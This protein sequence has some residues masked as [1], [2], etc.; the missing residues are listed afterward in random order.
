MKKFPLFVPILSVLLLHASLKQYAIL[1][2]GESAPAIGVAIRLHRLLCLSIIYSNDTTFH[3]LSPN[4]LSTSSTA[5][6]IPIVPF[7][8]R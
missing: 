8:I 1:E 6:V 2:E 5:S 4:C 3:S 7:T